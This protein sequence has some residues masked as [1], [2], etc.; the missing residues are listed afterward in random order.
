ML[1]L[2]CVV[3]ITVIHHTIWDQSYRQ[4]GAKKKK[5]ETIATEIEESD[6][7]IDG[8]NSLSGLDEQTTDDGIHLQTEPEANESAPT[9]VLLT[10]SGVLVSEFH[11]QEPEKISSWG[12]ALLLMASKA[13]ESIM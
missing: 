8:G 4:N 12:N 7:D 1:S 10:V 9:C 3:P 2:S 5:K 11:E 13:V 6:G